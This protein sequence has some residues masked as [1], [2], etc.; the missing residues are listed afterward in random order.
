MTSASSASSS[1]QMLLHRGG[2]ARGAQL[3]DEGEE[4]DGRTLSLRSRRGDRVTADRAGRRSWLTSFQPIAPYAT[5][6]RTEKRGVYVA[7]QRERAD[8]RRTRSTRW[9]AIAGRWRS[10]AATSPAM[11]PGVNE[12]ISANLAML[13][14]LEDV[15]TRLLADQA[16]V[17]E[18]HRRGARARRAGARQARPGPRRDRGHDPGLLG[19]D[20]PR[21][22]ARRAHGRLRRGD[23]AGPEGLLEHRD[24]R[25]QDQHARAQRHDR[26]GARRRG[27]PLASRSSPPR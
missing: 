8:G 26:G 27:G 14:S 17:S 15:T 22:P 12:R 7:T 23:G 2:N 11:S 16:Q 24:D 10:N 3:V 6:R 20:R 13:D 21:R 4:H 5:C 9:P 1:G 19:A 18:F 25:Q